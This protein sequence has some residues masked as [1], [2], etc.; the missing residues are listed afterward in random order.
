MAD[1]LAQN[2]FERFTGDDDAAVLSALPSS[3]PKTFEDNWLDF[4]SGKTKPED[5]EGVWSKALG[6]MANA[7]GGVVVWGIIAKKHGKPPVDAAE[8]L[9]LVDDV[10]AFAS[11]LIEIS[12][13]ATDPPLGGVQV[14]PI[15]KG[16]GEKEGFVVCLIPEGSVKPYMS[17]KAK[18]P[19]YL[20]VGDES[21]GTSVANRQ[22]AIL[23]RTFQQ[24][25]GYGLEISKDISR[26]YA[27]WDDGW[28]A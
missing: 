16:K 1:S 28:A 20:R 24:N 26:P 6:A 3:H 11:R 5:L 23:P 10:N 2:Y 17:L 22:T 15:P 12:R 27:S 7:G 18:R 9:A 19:F 14:K 25:R 4:K 21:K 13:F 8:S